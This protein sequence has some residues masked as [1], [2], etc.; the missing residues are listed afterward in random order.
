LSTTD[1]EFATKTLL[2]LVPDAKD[3]TATTL[4]GGVSC[5]TIKV[6]WHNGSGVIKRALAQLRVPGT[7]EADVDRILA[8]GDAITMYHQLTPEFVPKLLGRNDDELAIMLELAPEDM[9]EWR[10]QM[11]EGIVNPTIGSELG[12]VLG[13][14]HN[15]TTGV[16]LPPR[17][18]NGKKRLYDLRAGAFYG[19]MA[20]IWPEYESLISSC[21]K[22]LM[23]SMECAVHGD[24]SPKNILAGPS[25]TWVLD[26]EVTHKGAPVFD[27]AFMCAHLII[28]SIHL[29]DQRDLLLETIANFL[30][31]YKEQRGEIPEN[32]GHHVG[33]ITAVRVVG[34][35]QVK[36]LND[37]AKVKVVEIARSLLDGADLL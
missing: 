35:S 22:E 34:I 16:Q 3:I 29:E 33:I 5:D 21:A 18:E 13:I 8:E 17:I 14:W 37:S 19:G 31:A 23:E 1:V 15:K 10:L 6:N 2:S 32:L 28:K 30:K 7:W 26:F 27:L 24:F 20:K 36:Y 12:K 9:S 4:S 25:G 11:L